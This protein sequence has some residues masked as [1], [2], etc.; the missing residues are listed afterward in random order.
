MTCFDKFLETIK[1]AEKAM[2]GGQE[3]Y[4][5]D[6]D[7]NG[8]RHFVGLGECNCFDYFLPCKN[9]IALIEETRL[10]ESMPLLPK[11]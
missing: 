7:K 8:M 5:M 1:L 11:G 10:K 2:E 9:S 3:A 6:S 4:K